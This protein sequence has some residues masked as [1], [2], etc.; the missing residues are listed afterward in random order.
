ML[1]NEMQNAKRKCRGYCYTEEVKEFAVTVH[2]YL[3]KAYSCI[4][5]IFAPPHQSSIRNWISSVV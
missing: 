4:H 1:K 3:P 2:F 5:T